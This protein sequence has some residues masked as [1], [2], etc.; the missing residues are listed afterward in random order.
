[1]GPPP[2]HSVA[3][4]VVGNGGTLLTEP[5]G[6]D[7]RLEL[8]ALMRCIASDRRFGSHKFYWIDHGSHTS[9]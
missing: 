2:R 6:V 8:L 9:R 1:M 7:D 4:I 5:S 3:M